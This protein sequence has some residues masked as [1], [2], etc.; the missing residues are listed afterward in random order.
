MKFKLIILI[1]LI[2]LSIAV[3]KKNKYFPSQ[4]G[5]NYRKGIVNPGDNPLPAVY[6]TGARVNT[7]H[8]FRTRRAPEEIK[9]ETHTY[10]HIK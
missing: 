9:R 3:A 5:R 2:V 7:N 1:S 4:Y 6:Y 8:N 10:H